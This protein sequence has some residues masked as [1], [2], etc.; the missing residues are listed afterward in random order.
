MAILYIIFLS[1]V[2]FFLMQTLGSPISNIINFKQKYDTFKFYNDETSAGHNIL[3]NIILPNIF[4]LFIYEFNV[5]PLKEQLFYVVVGYLIIRYFTIIFIFGRK[6]LLNLKYE[7][8]LIIFTLVVTYWICKQIISINISLKVPIED[9]KNEILLIVI[10]FL[11]KAF[12]EILFSKFSDRKNTTNREKYIESFYGYFHKQYDGLINMI[13]EDIKKEISDEKT[14]NA[15]VSS[16]RKMKIVMYSI[17]IYENF[18]RPKFFRSFERLASVFSLKEYSTGVMQITSSDILTDK[19]SV[20]HAAQFIYHH[21]LEGLKN[22][23]ETQE[24]IPSVLET[25]NTSERNEY[26][27]E[28]MYIYEHLQEYLN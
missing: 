25:Y 10:L 3:F 26:G 22:G 21:F 14:R 4:I 12:K 13:F 15:F 28:V 1:I 23:E 19:A 7:L 9:F 24:I 18:S 17:M 27:Q 6:K 20:S 11:F 5:V 8:T 16:F 2:L